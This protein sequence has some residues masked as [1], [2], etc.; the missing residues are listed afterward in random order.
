MP[1]SIDDEVV[2]SCWCRRRDPEPVRLPDAAD[3]RRLG[4]AVAHEP[5]EVGLHL[6]LADVLELVP[7]RVDQ[8]HALLQA[9][10]DVVAQL[11]RARGPA[12]RAKRVRCDDCHGG[13]LS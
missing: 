5:F 13:L 8:R 12:K 7:V 3:E 1:A 9:H 4:H 2:R 6:E 11:G 10:A